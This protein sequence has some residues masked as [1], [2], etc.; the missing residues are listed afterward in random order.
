MTRRVAGF[1]ERIQEIPVRVRRF[2]KGGFSVFE[3]TAAHNGR[4]RKHL[5]KALPIVV[6]THGKQQTNALLSQGLQKFLQRLIIPFLTL[7]ISAVSR[8]HH[9]CRAGFQFQN[10]LNRLLYGFSGSAAARTNRKVTANMGIRHQDKTIGVVVF[11]G[12]TDG[13][14]QDPPAQAQDTAGQKRTSGKNMHCFS[15]YIIETVSVHHALAF[16]PIAMTTITDKRRVF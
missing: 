11:S 12:T 16:L 8:N 1:L 15:P 5:L 10:I 14:Q 9:R 7:V 6:V 2:N 4:V 13:R 3:G